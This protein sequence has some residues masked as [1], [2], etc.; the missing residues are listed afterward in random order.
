MALYQ[1]GRELQRIAGARPAPQI[2]RFIH[3][4][5]RASA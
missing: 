4:A 3:D 5:L 2:E 1:G